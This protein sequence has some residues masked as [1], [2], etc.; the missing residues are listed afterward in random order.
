[1]VECRYQDMEGNVHIF[2]SRCLYFN[3]E[4]LLQS[5]M[6]KVD[7]EG[8]NYKHYYVDIAEILPKVIRH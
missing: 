3:P 8:D 6:V 2:T 1:M 5:P 7:V 4:P